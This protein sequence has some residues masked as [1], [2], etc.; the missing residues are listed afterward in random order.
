MERH[1]FVYGV[2]LGLLVICLCFVGYFV[3]RKRRLANQIGPSLSTTKTTVS[4]RVT[5]PSR[6]LDSYTSE[7][8]WK[9]GQSPA[10]S[11]DMAELIHDSQT[12]Q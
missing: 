7:P 6:P 2:L 11:D 8:P 12:P 4:P 9:P 10:F 5:T 1:Q 3:V